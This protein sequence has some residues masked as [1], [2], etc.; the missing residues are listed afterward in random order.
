MLCGGE[1]GRMND[2]RIW[3]QPLDRKL[4]AGVVLLGDKG[5]VGA[6]PTIVTL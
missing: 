6:L 3:D 2:K 5:Y 4:P 1:K